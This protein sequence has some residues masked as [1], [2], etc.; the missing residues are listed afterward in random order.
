VNEGK[1]PLLRPLVGSGGGG[2]GSVQS[3]GRGRGD[4]AFGMGGARMR[5]HRSEEGGVGR[6]EPCVGSITNR[7]P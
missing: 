5:L 1:R 3:W 4:G 6:Q 2:A 7:G